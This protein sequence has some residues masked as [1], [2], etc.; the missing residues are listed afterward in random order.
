MR[1]EQYA[2][3]PGYDPDGYPVH[4]IQ[5]AACTLSYLS[6]TTTETVITAAPARLRGVVAD[7]GN[8]GTL[9]LRD[10]AA[11]GG[12]NVKGAVR[13]DQDHDYHGATFENGI[14]AQLSIGTDA[15][16]ILCRPV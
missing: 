10:S 14:T 4:T 2:N 8:L 6:N 9:T 15:V 7:K 16:A 12:S 3:K 13:A 11:T 1:N 5:D